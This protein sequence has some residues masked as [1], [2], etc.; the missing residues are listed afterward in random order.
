MGAQQSSTQSSHD[1]AKSTG[2]S[3]QSDATA[4]VEPME[5]DDEASDILDH[6]AKLRTKYDVY[7]Q[8]Y[9]EVQKQL[10]DLNRQLIEVL[11]KNPNV[12]DFAVNNFSIDEISEILKDFT[13]KTGVEQLDNTYKQIS[14][15]MLETL[16]KYPKTAKAVA[17][18]VNNLISV[19]DKKNLE[20]FIKNFSDDISNT[21]QTTKPVP[22]P[23]PEKT[24]E[25]P[26][27]QPNLEKTPEQTTKQP[28]QST[29]KPNPNLQARLGGGKRKNKKNCKSIRRKSN[30]R[31]SNRRKTNRRKSNRRKTNRKNK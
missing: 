3:N 1:T 23:N 4:S 9:Q 8:S 24:P 26:T 28:T 19:D 14:D 5:G 25:K 20:N 18:V 13:S 16:G 21:S 12:L 31:K 22:Q 17:G 27:Q 2:H 11:N 15:K 30:R 10:N 6:I 7:K 29:Q